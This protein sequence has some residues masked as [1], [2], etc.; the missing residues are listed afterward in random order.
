M[1]QKS[2]KAEV[3]AKI[4]LSLEIVGKVGDLHALK[5]LVA[6][7]RGY[8]DVVEFIPSEGEGIGD[9]EASASFQGFDEARFLEFFL[10]KAQAICAKLG[11]SGKL[12][13]KKGVPLGAGLGGSSASVVGALKAMR[14]YAK[15]LG[16]SA[17][18]DDG[19][20]LKLGSDVPCMLLGS[21]CIVEGAGERVT[22]VEIPI[23]LNDLRVEI[24]LGGSDTKACYALY[25]KL[26][27]ENT[28]TSRLSQRDYCEDLQ[29]AGKHI[30]LYKNDLT[31]PAATL[32]GNIKELICNLQKT[33]KI[34]FLSGSGSAVVYKSYKK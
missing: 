11:V 22:P 13:V 24:A 26:K 20:L 32:N 27:A 3:F 31:L 16:K 2:Y 18:L 8:K 10:S 21:P 1:T 23:D 7:Y 28:D 4:N 6:P 12:I 29:I 9:I 14:E 25:D 19:F 5:M 34:V 33:C 30:A 17:A 15:D